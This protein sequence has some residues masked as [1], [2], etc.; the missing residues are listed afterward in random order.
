MCGIIGFVSKTDNYELINKLT[1]SIS[2]RGPDQKSVKIYPFGEKYLHLGSARLAVTGLSDGDMPMHDDHGNALIYNGEIYD[3]KR[4][5]KEFNID[6][7]STSDTR[8]LLNLL[9]NNPASSLQEINGMFAFA[10]FNKVEE[11]LV[12]SRDKLG[13]KPLFYGTNNKFD[14]YFSSEIK[15]LIDNKI[16][17]RATTEKQIQDYL[18]FGG[19]TKKNGLISDISAIEPGTTVE[20]DSKGSVSSQSLKIT[21]K[22]GNYK[23]SSKEDFKEIFC[24]V[25]D[26]QLEAEVPVNLLLSGGVDS[27]LIALFAKKYLNKDVTAFTLGYKSSLYDER[28]VS[29]KIVDELSINNKQFQFPENQNFEIIDEVVNRLPEPISDPSIIPT[30]Y[31]AKQVSNYTKVVISGDGGD[32]I[33][34][35]YQ[36]YRG[37]LLSKKIPSLSY[38]L[39]RPL[40]KFLD[41]FNDNYIPYSEM[42]KLLSLGKNLSLESKI[43]LWQNYIPSEKLITQV[44]SYQDYLKDLNIEELDT[45][46][47]LKKLDIDSYLYT[48][49]LKKSDT[50]SMLNG[51][52]VRPVF[53]DNRI[54]NFSE[55]LKFSDNV[56]S[57][58]SK[59]FLKKLL[60]KELPNVQVYKK[61]GFAHDFGIWTDEVG[62]KYLKNN[63]LENEHVSNLISHLEEKNESNYFKSRYVWK[64]YSIFKWLDLNKVEIN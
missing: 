60:K 29:Q 61:K 2:H 64:Y 1:Q 59:L 13:I 14:F 41:R 39:F 15:P 10:Y 28:I 32:E 11:K 42:L 51:L 36:W 45:L 58:D 50:A 52:E 25:L 44:N 6:L 46:E 19:I 57:F 16:V 5:R 23:K 30:Y 22:I 18:Y 47:N 27:T 20:Y 12:I 49:I 62:L 40:G 3:L 7:N 53:L 9:S 17:N 8:H 26:N 24:E 4:L 33:F 55:N 54:I 56:N 21:N 63:W 38:K 43:L 35:G 34:G 48:N 31:L 37:A